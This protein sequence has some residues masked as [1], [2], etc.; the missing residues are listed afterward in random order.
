MKKEFNVTGTCFSE[1]H[2]MADISKKVEEVTQMMGKGRYFIINRPR[3]YGKTTTIQT[4]T[5]QF[6]ESSDYLVFTISFAGIG[7]DIFTDEKIFSVGFLELLADYLEI[8]EENPE[9]VAWLNKTAAETVTLKLLSKAITQLVK[10]CQK[11]VILLIDEV[12]K[13]SNNQ[14]FVSFLAML[15]DKYLI[16]TTQKTFHSIVLAGVHDV[17]SLK[18]KLRHGEESKLNSPWNI[19]TDFKVDMNLY[20][21]E[22]KPMLLD[23]MS[24][25][26]VKMDAELIAERLFYHTSGYPF[27]VSR[28]C[29]MM[30][31]EILPA[32]NSQEWTIQDMD[33]AARFI[34]KE[35]NANFDSLTKNL[36]DNSDL[37]NQ[38]YMVAVENRNTPFSIHDSITNLG[39]IYGI[40]AEKNGITVIHNRI[41]N[42]VIVNW[43]TIRMLRLQNKN[44][45]FGGAYR[46]DDNTLN[47]EAVLLGFQAFMKKEYSKKD[48]DFLE[49]NGRLVF[50]A[51]LKP[52][53]NGSGYDFK[54][55]QISEERRLDVVVT[56]FEHK[57]VAELKIWRG[58]KAHDKGLVQLADYLERQ[59]LTEGYL[60]I[61]DHSE[62][63]K[64]DSDW[65]EKKGKKIFI[66]WV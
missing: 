65:T 45:D 19:A 34:A 12:D 30:D 39:V 36:E 22:I 64:W 38:V 63:K 54:E 13:S 17:K 24:E 16:R 21:I 37:Y 7:D 59:A 33:M 4:L 31:E 47:M 50:L 1:L 43:M 27:L 29:K 23:Y 57:Y 55:P 48:R 66:V 14:L 3:Q 35:S 8:D 28:L 60:L 32:K 40:F 11:K 61:F 20:P 52:I 5:N 56:Y 2:Y 10:K 18:I 15:R 9:L 42:E 26:G 53:I 51:F 41:Y 58:E 46:N 49:K 62:V 25:T 44:S 6:K